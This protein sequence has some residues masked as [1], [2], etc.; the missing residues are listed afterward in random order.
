MVK[1]AAISPLDGLQMFLSS[2]VSSPELKSRYVLD[3][4]Y[5]HIHIHIYLY[6]Y[7]CIYT[8][9]CLYVC[10]Y[11]CILYYIY[12]YIDVYKSQFQWL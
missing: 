5:I 1:Q 8:Y 10:M 12:R 6:L 7:I 9:V 3:T 2:Y 4:L 11:V